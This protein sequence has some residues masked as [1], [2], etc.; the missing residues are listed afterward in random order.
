M[1]T[2][3][4]KNSKEYK[5]ERKSNYPGTVGDS[6]KMSR[7]HGGNIRE[8]GKE[9]M[10]EAKGTLLSV[11]IMVTFLQ[12][13]GKYNHSLSDARSASLPDSAYQPLG[14]TLKVE[15]KFPPCSTD[16]ALRFLE[17]TP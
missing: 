13:R 9:A 4:F 7:M 14:S 2:E 17:N 8:E 11:H 6:Q 5:K 15:G 12:T 10:L 1:T 16:Q 3:K